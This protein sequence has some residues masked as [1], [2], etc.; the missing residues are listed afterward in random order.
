LLFGFFCDE[1]GWERGLF[2]V[3]FL[4]EVYVAFLDLVEVFVVW[5]LGDLFEEVSDLWACAHFVVE[6]AEESELEA[7]LFDCFGWHFCF[8]VPVDDAYGCVED[9]DVFSFV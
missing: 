7:A 2:V 5:V 8:H 3:V 1:F 6:F 4:D 9:D